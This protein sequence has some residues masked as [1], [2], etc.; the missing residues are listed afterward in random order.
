MKNSEE[1]LKY[2]KKRENKAKKKCIE[3]CESDEGWEDW[4]PANFYQFNYL[5][6]SVL[7][8]SEMLEKID[9]KLK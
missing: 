1:I 9:R 4:L 6:Y 3:I 7:K 8:M 2:I 5:T